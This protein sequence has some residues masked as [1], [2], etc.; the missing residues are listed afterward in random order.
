[1]D[2]WTLGSDSEGHCS[3]GEGSACAG[4]T[5]GSRIS[6]P[7]GAASPQCSWT[8]MWCFLASTAQSAKPKE[9][10]ASFL[11]GSKSWVAGK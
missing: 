9:E 10:E 2:A 11:T 7:E 6:F 1:M 3:A 5:P 4:V 8:V